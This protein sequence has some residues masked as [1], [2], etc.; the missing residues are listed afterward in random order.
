MDKN[1]L[2]NNSY[3]DENKTKKKRNRPENKIKTSTKR[4]TYGNKDYKESDDDSIYKVK[5]EK[6]KHNYSENGK[7]AKNGKHTLK[8]NQ[9]HKKEKK[10]RKYEKDS[11]A[12]T[13][14]D[15]NKGHE[16]T[17]SEIPTSPEDPEDNKQ[18]KNQ[19][20]ISKE[21]KQKLINMLSNIDASEGESS[22]VNLFLIFIIKDQS[23]IRTK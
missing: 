8:Q 2:K 13:D 17:R 11:N 23:N 5:S 21:E 18:D 22:T 15:E 6:H 1:G 7:S 3:S 14:L 16:K 10:S 12:D 9:K 4:K 20:V 19:C